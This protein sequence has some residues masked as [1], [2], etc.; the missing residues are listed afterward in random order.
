MIVKLWEFAEDNIIKEIAKPT[1]DAITSME[2]E[3][4]TEIDTDRKGTIYLNLSKEYKTM[5]YQYKDF[6]NVG[7]CKICEDEN[8]L[9]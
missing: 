8:N 9:Y 4:S 3:L 6:L 2:S 1:L 7:M 5:F